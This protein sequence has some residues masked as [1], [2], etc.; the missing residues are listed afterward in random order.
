MET[1]GKWQEKGH[2]ID[3]NPDKIAKDIDGAYD[4]IYATQLEKEIIYYNS[5]DRK[6]SKNIPFLNKT[7]EL[8]PNSIKSIKI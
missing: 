4:G 3:I 6:V 2:V 1:V 5:T 7:I 8:E